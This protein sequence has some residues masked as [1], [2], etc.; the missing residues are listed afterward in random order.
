[1]SKK[2]FEFE[3]KALNVAKY[4]TAIADDLGKD[5]HTSD[6]DFA[7]LMSVAL[8]KMVKAE[9]KDDVKKLADAFKIAF[10]HSKPS[11]DIWTYLCLNS[12]WLSWGWAKEGEEAL[13]KAWADAWYDL[14]DFSLDNL[15]GD[16][17]SY[18]IT[19]VD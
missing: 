3:V 16:D 2:G 15:K 10:K 7:E 12:N 19:E 9:D 4:I 18:Y 6:S 1:M 11:V 5:W 8:Y 17:L 13:S 14:N